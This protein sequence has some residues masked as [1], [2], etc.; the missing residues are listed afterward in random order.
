MIARHSPELNGETGLLNS[1]AEKKRE[2]WAEWPEQS[3]LSGPVC[4]HI[5]AKCGH[6][7]HLSGGMQQ[8]FSAVQTV[9]RRGR[10]SITA[11]SAI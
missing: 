6:I 5:I 11:D 8:N 9:W 4:S 7:S 3:I 10:D 2:V 1:A